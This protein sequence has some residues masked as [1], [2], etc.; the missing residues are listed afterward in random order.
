MGLFDLPAPLFALLDSGLGTFAPP[1]ARLLIW[2]AVGAA[3]SMGLYWL[4][5]P[6]RRI[7]AAKA[8]ALA[9]RQALDAHEGEFGAAWPLMRRMLALALRQLGL[10]L[11]PAVVAS[12]PVLFLLAWLSTAYGYG[13]PTDEAAVAVRVTPEAYDARL[14][15]DSSG[16]AAHAA[17]VVDGRGE[18]ALRAPLPAPVT[19]LHKRQWWNAL[20]G[21]PAGYLPAA[22]EIEWIELDLPERRYLPFGPAWLGA[23]YTVFFTSLLVVSIVIKV[24]WRIE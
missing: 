18:E 8:E 4:I 5:S 19:M 9:A 1:L 20:F 16:P 12:L 15:Q 17:V 6:Q 22:G 2:G 13:F 21:N 3:I 11:L 7:T 14:E 23:W 24:V 10:V